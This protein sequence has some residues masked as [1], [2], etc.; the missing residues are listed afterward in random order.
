MDSTLGNVAELLAL[1][2]KT[3]SFWQCRFHTGPAQANEAR[4]PTPSRAHGMHE[5][6]D[7]LR[8][9]ASPPVDSKTT[10]N[11]LCPQPVDNFVDRSFSS[12]WPSLGRPLG[13]A[14]R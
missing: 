8:P 7:E 5:N 2:D 13:G 11:F 10:T 1:G 4:T 6:C 3:V 9:A 14:S 12:I